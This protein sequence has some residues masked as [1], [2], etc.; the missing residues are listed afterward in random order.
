MTREEALIRAEELAFTYISNKTSSEIRAIDKELKD[1]FEAY[2]IT[3]AEIDE[4]A[5]K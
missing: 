3:W 1:L 4:G 2:D 5:S